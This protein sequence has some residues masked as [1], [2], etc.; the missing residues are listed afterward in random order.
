MFHPL[1]NMKFSGGGRG[2]PLEGVAAMDGAQ[3]S[4]GLSGLARI[5]LSMASMESCGGGRTKVSMLVLAVGMGL[6]LSRAA[7]VP[8]TEYSGMQQA[9][10]D[11]GSGTE[12]DAELGGPD[13]SGSDAAT[14]G[15]S[16]AGSGS[17]DAGRGPLGDCIRDRIPTPTGNGCTCSWRDCEAT[18]IDCECDVECYLQDSDCLISTDSEGHGGSTEDTLGACGDISCVPED[19]LSTEMSC[20]ATECEPN[21]NSVSINPESA[22]VSPEVSAAD[23]ER[24]PVDVSVLFLIDN[25]GSMAD[26]QM[27]ATCAISDFFDAAGQKGASYRTGV[28]STNLFGLPAD[29]GICTDRFPTY[30]RTGAFVKAP[31]LLGLQGS[32]GLGLTCDCPG[33]GAEPS[34]VCA[35]NDQGTWLSSSDPASQDTLRKLIIQGDGCYGYEAGLER[36]FQFFAEMERQGTFNTETPYE[37]VV[38]SDEDPYAEGL[39]CPFD[40]LQRN[41]AGIP[42]FAPPAT[43]NTLASCASDLK[44]FYKYYFTSRK[45]TIHGI[46]WMQGCHRDSQEDLPDGYQD[47]I[48][49]TGGEIVSICECNAFPDFFSKVGSRTADLSTSLCLAEGVDPDPA[50]IE[51][52][53]TENNASEPVPESATDGWTLDADRNCLVFSGSWGDRHGDYH[54]EYVDRN[55]PLPP[56]PDPVACLDPSLEVLPDTLV[57]KCDGTIVPKSAT[58][59]WTFDD[60]TDCLTLHGSWANATCAFTVDYF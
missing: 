4:G 37:V 13:A 20:E 28:I 6:M 34:Q 52:T 49:A 30:A 5:L 53:Y 9:A 11:G 26:D 12:A 39:I 35:F 57:V 42:N 7:C 40:K 22:P 29:Y 16:D 54:V 15:P 14:P 51:V 59:G 19:D 50:T 18:A 38:I 45:I 21:P 47:L 31:S 48:T 8:A 23:L 17:L 41:T 46:H 10:R 58:N 60:S 55:I 36:A 25:S 24:Q 1:P 33:T 56:P 44:A 27:A 2:C 43:T 32:C 3:A